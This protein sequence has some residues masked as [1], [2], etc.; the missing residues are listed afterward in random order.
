MEFFSLLISLIITVFFVYLSYRIVS[1]AGF[2]GWWALTTLVPLLNIVM[3]IIFAFKPWPAV[4]G[5]AAQRS[6]GGGFQAPPP[7]A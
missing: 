2:N 5:A 7:S 1:K 6:S 4:D 3:I